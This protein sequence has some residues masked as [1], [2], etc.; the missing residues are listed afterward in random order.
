MSITN[1]SPAVKINATTNKATVPLKIL[2]LLA[3]FF[4]D[5]PVIT[6]VIMKTKQNTPAR[7]VPTKGQYHMIFLFHKLQG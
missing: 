2:F 7:I 1:Q 4:A 3:L 5:L 6:N